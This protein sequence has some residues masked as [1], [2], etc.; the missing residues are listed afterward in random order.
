VLPDVTPKSDDDMEFT[1][2]L[3]KV[4]DTVPLKILIACRYPYSKG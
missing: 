1:D 2:P 4:Q 3:S